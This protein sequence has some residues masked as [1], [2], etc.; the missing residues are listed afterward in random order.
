MCGCVGVSLSLSLS[1][2]LSVCLSV[3][4]SI[5]LLP[6]P[7]LSLALSLSDLFIFLCSFACCTAAY[8]SMFFVSL[9]TLIEA[10]SLCFWRVIESIIIIAVVLVFI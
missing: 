10:M 2:S 6:P 5:S 9:C 3:C 8:Y 4:R 7:P 1:L